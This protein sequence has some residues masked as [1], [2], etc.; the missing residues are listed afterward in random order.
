MSVSKANRIGGGRNRFGVVLE[1]ASSG[2]ESP[3]LC[4][5]EES[6]GAEL[7]RKNMQKF[8]TDQIQVI[9]GVA[10]E[11]LEALEM[12]TH[13]FIGG[14]TGQLKRNYSVHKEKKSGRPYRD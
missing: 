11:A 10:P 7:I 4:N 8:R 9:E 3:R 1:A 12:P 14:S 13:A 5:R 6:G 2:R